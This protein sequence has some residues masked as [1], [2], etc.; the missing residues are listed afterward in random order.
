MGQVHITRTLHHSAASVWNWISD[1]GNIHRIHP[2]LGRSWVEGE[3]SCGVGAERVCEMKVGG[4]RLR[5]RVTDWHENQS[6]TV[7]VYETSLPLVSRARATL[8]VR[9]LGAAT[10]VAYIHVRYETRYGVFGRIMDV[11]VLNL[12]M[13]AMMKLVLRKL[14][15]S[16]AETDRGPHGAEIAVGALLDPG[17]RDV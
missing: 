17:Q 9:E 3:R 10:S 13:T 2:A 14:E 1:Y 15:R 4:F 5:E 12:M 8:G 6:Y 16:L 11:L 7:D